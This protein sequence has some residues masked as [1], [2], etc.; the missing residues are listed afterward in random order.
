M[1][2]IVLALILVHIARFGIAPQ[3]DEGTAA[4]LFQILMPAQIPIITFFAIKWLPHS[5]RQAL[6]VLALQGAAAF[7]V[8]A[9]VFFLHW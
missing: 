7:A 6:R 3:T 5:P 1:S 8:L 9:V 4:H 2:S